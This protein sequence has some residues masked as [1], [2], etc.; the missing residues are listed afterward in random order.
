MK[1][2]LF[3]CQ[4]KAI[5][6][7]KLNAYVVSE[8]SG[9]T[10]ATPL[11]VFIEGEGS[12]PNFDETFNIC[13]EA[14]WKYRLCGITETSEME[15]SRVDYNHGNTITITVDMEGESSI[16]SYSKDFVPNSE[17]ATYIFKTPIGPE[18]YSVGV[19]YNGTVFGGVWHVRGDLTIRIKGYDACGESIIGEPGTYFIDKPSC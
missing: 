15:A 6:G 1:G 11:S 16:E 10:S 7:T 9:I 12:I 18:I 17:D 19:R 4:C 2:Y 5:D 3:N 14:A 13:A 8:T